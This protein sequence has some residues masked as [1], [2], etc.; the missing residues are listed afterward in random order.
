MPHSNLDPWK[1][2]RP[3]ER[4][5]LVLLVAGLVYIA[6]GQSLI[7]TEPSAQRLESLRFALNWFGFDLPLVFW[8]W[9]FVS[10]GVA[11]IV[12]ARWPPIS[13]TWGYY[14]LTGLSSAWA[15]FYLMG[16]LFGDAP[17]MNISA[18]LTWGLIAFMWWGISGLVNPSHVGFT[19]TE[20]P[21]LRLEVERL[22]AENDAL[23]LGKE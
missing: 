3:W 1:A 5:S 13:E 16:I 22:R 11:A 8:G 20:I 23:R 9:G 21:R 17:A 18:V 6:I 4:H 15:L 2:I 7:V 19:L 12:S 10:H 14:L